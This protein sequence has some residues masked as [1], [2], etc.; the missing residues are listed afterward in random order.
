[1]I[2]ALES[3]TLKLL[4][5]AKQIK[6]IEIGCREYARSKPHK[7]I[8]D[9]QGKETA[10]LR[11]SP[12]VDIAILAGEAVYQMRSSLDHLAFDLVKLN[13]IGTPLPYQWEERCIFPL[14]TDPAKPPV[15]NCF[16]GYVPNI[17]KASFAFI[18]SVQP[19][20]KGKPSVICTPTIMGWLARLSNI[21]KH[22]HLNVIETTLSHREVVTT[23][24]GTTISVAKSGIKHGAEIQPRVLP[25]PYPTVNV[26]R[27]FTPYVAFK[28]LGVGNDTMFSV[29]EVLKYCLGAIKKDLIP[30]FA[31]LL[32]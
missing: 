29:P 1:M 10:D 11:R 31:E 14:W 32:K 3:A 16:K 19:Y 25:Q 8:I 17:S 22:R 9:E 26:R 2:T 4:R 30:A 12:P 24:G 13:Q 23:S 5:V 6:V 21:D 15:Y 20:R 27:R 7:I 28:E 18:E